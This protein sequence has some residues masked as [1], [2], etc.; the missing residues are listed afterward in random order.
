MVGSTDTTSYIL[1][2]EWEGKIINVT[3][4]NIFRKAPARNAIPNEIYVDEKEEM[5]YVVLNGNDEIM[6]IRMA[7]KAIVWKKSSGGVALSG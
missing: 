5:L 7:D 3:G 4:M 2:A 6:K 1:F